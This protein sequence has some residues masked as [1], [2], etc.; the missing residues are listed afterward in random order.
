M[1]EQKEDRLVTQMNEKKEEEEGNSVLCI[2]VYMF[3][4]SCL[5][6]Y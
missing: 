3:F 1:K 2:Y 6:Y 5:K 4:F